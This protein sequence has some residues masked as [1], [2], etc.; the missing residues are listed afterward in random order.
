MKMLAGNRSIAV[1]PLA[2]L[3][4]GSLLVVLKTVKAIPAGHVGV[5]DQWG[6]VSPQPLQ[7]GLNLVSP[8][9]K[10]VRFSARTQELKETTVTPS[11][12]GLNLTMDVSLLYRVVPEQAQ[13]IYK[14]VGTNYQEVVLI[15]LFRSTVRNVTATY[16][17]KA[18]Y[19]SKRV[20]MAQK[21]REQLSRSLANRGIVI[22][23][24]ALRKVDLPANLQAAVEEKLKAEQEAQRMQFVLEKERQEAERRRIEARGI[25][26]AQK[27]IAQ[28]LNE[29]TLQWRTI[30]ATEKLAQSP[31]AKVIVVGAGNKGVPMLLQP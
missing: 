30:E 12:D 17:A 23:E 28:G 6:V 10:V 9:A 22:D 19:T 16:D 31:N 5:V 27:I 2:T 29:N 7:P 20:E 13:E 21:I 3:L 11:Q 18:L 24:V 14:T 8:L 25:A 15:P 4:L 1:V 26:D